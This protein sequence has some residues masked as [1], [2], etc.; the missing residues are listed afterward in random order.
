MT[1]TR[2]TALFVAATGA[3]LTTAFT[4]GVALA[5]TGQTSGQIPRGFLLYEAEAR[6]PV[7]P[8]LGE[9]WTISN[10]LSSNLAFNP[11][12]LNSPSDGGRVSART[13]EYSFSEVHRAEQ[14]VLYRTAG[15]ARSAMS[16]LL[17]QVNRCKVDKS[18]SLVFKASAQAVGIGDQAA[19]L[20]IQAYDKNGRPVVGGQRAV[21]VRKGRALALYL[22]GA[23]YHSVKSD[24]FSEQ[25]V[26][27]R[28][29][30]GKVCSLPGVC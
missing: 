2:R 15:A 16:G 26:D 5:E 23:E 6:K 24:H 7:D 25:L 9:K 12:T 22:H 10:K 13:I 30:A 21:V 17:A 11:C 20:T 29:M 4:G 3:A 1:G 18:G 27:A 14:L 28:R 19:R 8:S